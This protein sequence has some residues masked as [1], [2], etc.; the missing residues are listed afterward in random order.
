[1][2]FFP[3]LDLLSPH[4]CK[5]LQSSSFICFQAQIQW[6]TY[7]SLRW[8]STF[9]L[10]IG[11]DPA[12]CTSLSQVLLWGNA[13]LWLARSEPY[14]QYLSTWIEL[15]QGMFSQNKTWE[16]A[17]R[18]VEEIDAGLSKSSCILYNR[19]YSQVLDHTGNTLTH[20]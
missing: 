18:C 12:M 4:W 7:L 17:N 3:T 6:K 16:G 11:Y 14:C 13:K 9:F 15:E 5:T 19:S 1:M 20:E 2:D 10:C 8:P